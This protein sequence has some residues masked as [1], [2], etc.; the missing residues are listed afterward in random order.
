MVGCFAD[1]CF[2]DSVIALVFFFSQFLI[3][4]HPLCFFT[5]AHLLVAVYIFSVRE[6]EWIPTCLDP[7]LPKQGSFTIYM[8]IAFRVFPFPFKNGEGNEILPIFWDPHTKIET[9]IQ[10][11]A[12][13]RPPYRKWNFRQPHTK[14]AFSRPPY[15]NRIFETPVQKSHFSRCPSPSKKKRNHKAP[16]K[17]WYLWKYVN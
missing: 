6:V 13:S 4:I 11:L 16:K 15:K 7:L 8:Y 10:K 14:M 5:P 9:P 12:F 1:L 3:L 17:I 2:V